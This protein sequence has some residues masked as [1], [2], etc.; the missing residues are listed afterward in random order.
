MLKSILYIGLASVAAVIA[1]FSP[2]TGAIACVEA[3]L[4][5]PKAIQMQDWGFRYQL[6]T[7]VAF[8][9]GILI[10]RPKPVAKVGSEGAV[11]WLTWIFVLMCLL[12][13]FWALSSPGEALDAASD[14][15]KTMVV[16]TAF[17]WAIRS[18]T[19]G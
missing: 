14:M 13:S 6:W 2:I 18:T 16:A 19:S 9:A 12:S 4:F 10:K 17:I 15:I 7:S 11:V 5:N 8:L 1:L 3:Y